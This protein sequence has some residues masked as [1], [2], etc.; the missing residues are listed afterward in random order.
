VALWALAAAQKLGHER[1]RGCGPDAALAV[2]LYLKGVDK[3][4]L[5][6]FARAHLRQF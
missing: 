5:G 3:S 6:R 2:A 1:P 4:A